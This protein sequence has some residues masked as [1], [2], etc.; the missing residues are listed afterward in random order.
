MPITVKQFPDPSSS[1]WIP[2]DALQARSESLEI[3]RSSLERYLRGE[4]S[5]RSILISGHRGAGKTTLVDYSVRLAQVP[6][7]RPLRVPLY[8]PNLFPQPLQSETNKAKTETKADEK[9]HSDQKA[10][11]DQKSKEGQKPADD[12][13]TDAQRVLMELTVALY[14]S[15]VK[16]VAQSY[17]RVLMIG[18]R[19]RPPARPFELGGRLIL[20]LD[21]APGP[22]RLRKFWQMAGAL[23]WGVLFPEYRSPF[24]KFGTGAPD[25]G[26]RELVALSSAA[27]AFRV[28]A[29]KLDLSESKVE[30]GEDSNTRSSESKIDVKAL[31]VATLGLMS[32][33]F[34]AAGV[35]FLGTAA[36]AANSA[37][38]IKGMG[39]AL[40]AAVAAITSARTAS[41]TVTRK[42]TRGREYKFIRDFKLDTLGREL[43]NLIDRI[44]HA[45]LAPVFVVDEL[46]KVPNLAA[47]LRGLVRQLKPLVAE[48]TF[49]CFLTDRE[50]YEDLRAQSREIAYAPE[51]T[52]FTHRLFVSY[53]PQGLRAYLDGVLTA[54]AENPQEQRTL[55]IDILAMTYLMLYRARMHPFDLN[56]QLQRLAVEQSAGLRRSGEVRTDAG[57]RYAITYQLAV[58]TI[59]RQEEVKKR[60]GQDP[61]LGQ[62]IYDALYYPADRWDRSARKFD[63]FLKTLR[64]HLATRMHLSEMANEAGPSTGE[65]NP[66]P[67]ASASAKPKRQKHPPKADMALIKVEKLLSATD[68]EFIFN[69]LEEMIGLLANPEELLVPRLRSVGIDADI[70]TL[71]P[72]DPLL[73]LDGQVCT[74][75]FDAFGRPLEGLDQTRRGQLMRALPYIKAMD[76]EIRETTSTLGEML[77]L[78]AFSDRFGILD[79]SPAWA[80]VEPAIARL[81]G[82]SEQENIEG[83]AAKDAL[84][85]ITYSD[86]LEAHSANLALAII[87][88]RNVAQA[89]NVP[90]TAGLDAITKLFN[91]AALEP[92]GVV[93]ELRRLAKDTLGLGVVPGSPLTPDNMGRWDLR[94]AAAW[95]FEAPSVSLS[96]SRGSLWEELGRRW[97]QGRYV[98]GKDYI[99]TREDLICTAAGIGP[100]RFETSDLRKNTIANWTALFRLGFEDKDEE[101]ADY[102]PVWMALISASMLRLPAVGADLQHAQ[103]FTF[104]KRQRAQ[105]EFEQF[106]KLENSVR[107]ASGGTQPSNVTD[108]A[109]V[110]VGPKSPALEWDVGVKVVGLVAPR[111][112]ADSIGKICDALIPASS[113]QSTIRKS[114][115]AEA[116]TPS[117]PSGA[118]PLLRSSRL[119]AG[120]H[121]RRLMWA[122]SGEAS[123]AADQPTPI[124]GSPAI[125]GLK[126]MDQ[127][128][129]PP[130]LTA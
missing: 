75:K 83:D 88:G 111:E 115:L 30:S 70:V 20:D 42:V 104:K 74:F 100:S 14:R 50:Y 97:E 62:V 35:Y 66:A 12:Q 82:I 116:S 46:D 51:H 72:R 94:I 5:G 79:T 84:A 99:V 112:M 32:G 36:T 90:F 73:V 96:Q 80:A 114:I 61:Y 39:A 11:G 129:G 102:V 58:E 52:Y 91:F 118:A 18:P 106:R 22:D 7:A 6:G 43:P 49:F 87:C 29:G 23:R 1:S 127:S 38:M 33:L 24:T 77:N 85:I 124:F 8:G 19:G 25:Q 4:I 117:E 103:S 67:Q 55:E 71:V 92:G 130:G 109:F 128:S 59:L 13:L 40:A 37:D 126:L 98:R 54:D 15:L 81:D 26:I 57:F 119:F 86:K 63:L 41:R 68:L 28:V 123:S 45:G 48:R 89:A 16:E 101:E 21:D 120:V 108:F 110:A 113:Q 107:S 34:G 78:G 2:A 31:L 121:E 69:R 76:K 44:R 64:D 10:V 56:V 3:L 17:E 9:S 105:A 95:Q 60:L 47:N 65:T 122:R 125:D 93:T 27:Q 53:S